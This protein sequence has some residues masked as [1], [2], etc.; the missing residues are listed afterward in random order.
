MKDRGRLYYS[1][2]LTISA[3]VT[4]NGL[5]GKCLIFPVTRYESSLEIAT[6]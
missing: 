5:M 4:M 1:I 3:G 2:I 6:S